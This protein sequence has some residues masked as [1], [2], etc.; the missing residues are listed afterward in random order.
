MPSQPPRRNTPDLGLDL[1]PERPEVP[2]PEH[3]HEAP[4]PAPVSAETKVLFGIK[5][6][7]QFIALVITACG[8]YFGIQ[9]S[10]AKADSSA[11]DAGKVAAAAA[12]K[13]AEVAKQVQDHETTLKVIEATK[14]AEKEDLDRR[15]QE[16]KDTQVKSETRVLEAIKDLKVEIK[17]GK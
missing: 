3:N 13:T 7:L 1:F 12:L 5:D 16:V 14:K 4:A 2:P 6:L 17:R 15:F 9:A 10:V 11:E 8:L